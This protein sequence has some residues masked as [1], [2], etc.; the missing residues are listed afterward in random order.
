VHYGDW[1]TYIR[2][3][4]PEDIQLE[5]FGEVRAFLAEG[6]FDFPVCILKL[7]FLLVAILLGQLIAPGVVSLTIVFTIWLVM[8]FGIVGYLDYNFYDLLLNEKYDLGSDVPEEDP[9]IL[10][11]PDVPEEDL[12]V[13]EE[14]SDVPEE[15][16]ED[17]D[18]SDPEDDVEPLPLDAPRENLPDAPHAAAEDNDDESSS[19]D[20]T[21]P[22]PP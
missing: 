20:D 14:D 13:P 17:E 1:Y 7:Q 10:E 12:E 11:N 3:G 9:V 2:T 5:I 19:D 4:A 21:P 15:D 18:I 6:P 22:S 8:K 16:S